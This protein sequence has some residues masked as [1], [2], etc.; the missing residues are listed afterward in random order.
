MCLD[1][2]NFYISAPLD[3]YEYMKIPLHLFPPW[4]KCQYDLQQ[5]AFQDFGYIEM[6][7]A[8]WG[9]PQVG[10]LANKLLKKHLAPYV[11]YECANTPGLWRHTTSSLTF[12]LVVDDFGIK[13]SNKKDVK[14]L[15]K[16]LR[17]NYGLTEEWTS[18]LY[19]GISLDWNNTAQTLDISMPGYH[20]TPTKI[21]ARPPD[22]STTLSVCTPT[23]TIWLHGASNDTS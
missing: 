2:K 14:H 19:C 3:R 1:I 6:R 20:Q 13:Y 7:R 10:I 4:I 9:L 23:K 12:T 8:V 15:I 16:C 18:N 11:Y 22:T 21:Q 5:H 17:Q